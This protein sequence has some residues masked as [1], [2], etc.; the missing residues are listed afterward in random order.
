MKIAVC[1]SGQLRAMPHCIDSLQVA[2]PNCDVDTYATVWDYDDTSD[3]LKIPNLVK[4]EY[5][6]NFKLSKYLE[7][8]IKAIEEGFKNVSQVENW[9]PIPVWNLTRIELMAQNSFK[10]INRDYDY[11]VRA[12]YDTKFLKDI[13][14]LLSKDYILLTEDIGG[15]AEWDTWKD[16]RS[17]FDGFAAGSQ[18]KMTKYYGFADWLPNYFNHHSDTLKAERTLG[19]YLAKEAKVNTGFTIDILGIQVN[20]N[21]WYNRNN[22]IKTN[23]LKTK[24]KST[25]DFYKSDLEKNHPSVYKKIV[26]KFK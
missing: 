20:E 19:W 2:F 16:T 1:Y 18:E 22:P 17:V 24:Q 11:I 9:A 10:L 26:D 4:F 21:E 7:F 23:S 25:F 6:N 15:S 13:T 3:L 5:T 12:R 8:E 14:G